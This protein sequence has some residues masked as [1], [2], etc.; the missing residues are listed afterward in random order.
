[1]R[2]VAGCPISRREWIAGPWVHYLEKAAVEAGYDELLV[3]LVGDEESDP[4]TFAAVVDSISFA[5]VMVVHV[6]DHRAN[7]IR[8]WEP[9]RK[10]LMVDLRNRLLEEVRELCPD[11][12]LSVD[13]DILLHPRTIVN[14]RE[15]LGGGPFS[16]VGGRCYMHESGKRYVS[17]ANMRSNGQ[18]H[19]SD[20]DGVFPCDVIMAIKLMRPDAYFVDYRFQKHGEDIGWCQALKERGLC[21]GWDGRVISKHVIVPPQ[22]LR[23]STP[24]DLAAKRQSLIEEVDPR[25]GF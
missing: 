2:L 12:F 8:D 24:A 16:A 4:E 15:T 6:T 10:R 22:F 1:M 23:R 3:V 5:E 13:S 18:I 14:L 11:L 17:W 21:V 19:R 20:S 9:G 7:D 25:V